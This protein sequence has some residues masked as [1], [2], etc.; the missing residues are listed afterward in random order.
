MAKP[1]GADVEIIDRSTGTPGV[2]LPNAVRI[3]GTEILIPSD[4]KI[5][6]GDITEDELVTVT[7]TVVA[8]S[9]SIRR[10]PTE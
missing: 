10:E 8:R 4:A 9:L 3:N 7:L 1:Q 2:I 6:V 5:R